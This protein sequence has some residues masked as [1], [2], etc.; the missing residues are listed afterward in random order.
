MSDAD[1]AAEEVIATMLAAERPDDGLVAEEGSAREGSSGRRWIVD[2][3]DGTIN[4][5]YRFPAWCVSVALE[6]AVGVVLDPLRDE[7][8]AATRDSGP[9]LNGEPVAAAPPRPLAESLLATGFSY[10]AAVRTRQMEIIG[11][12]IGSVR[13]VRRM[14][15]AALDLA[16][17]AAG[18]YDAYF[19]RAVKPWDIAAGTLLCTCAGLSV[20]QLPARDGMP[21]GVI[22]GPGALLDELARFDP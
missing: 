4:Y 1:R 18:R 6:D 20:R 15:S 16:W 3:L 21:V 8:F 10:D 22:A 5:L 19:E 9:L 13:D 7:L 17:L 11:A 12:L 14:G 2:P